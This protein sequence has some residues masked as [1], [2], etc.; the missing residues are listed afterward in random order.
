MLKK[1]QTWFPHT[2]VPRHVKKAAQKLQS[3]RCLNRPHWLTIDA[4]I[5]L[6]MVFYTCT[7]IFPDIRWSTSFFQQYMP[8]GVEITNLLLQG[9]V[10]RLVLLPIIASVDESGGTSL[11]RI[12]ALPGTRD[13]RQK[14]MNAAAQF[15]SALMHNKNAILMALVILTPMDWM[16]H[17]GAELEAC[18]TPNI[19]L[20]QLCF[21]VTKG[22]LVLDLI[23]GTAH[24]LAHKGPFKR[25]LWKYHMKHHTQPRN[26]SAVKYHGEALDLEV[27]LTQVCYA[28]LPRILGMDLFTGMVLVNW[29]SF[30]LLLEHTGFSCFYLSVH[31]EIHHRYA[32]VA[33]YHFPLWEMIF[34]R[35]PKPRQLTAVYVR[36][37][38]NTLGEKCKRSDQYTYPNKM[39]PYN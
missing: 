23:L 25:W 31:H 16:R 26:Y 18:P 37:N 34:G 17:S 38:T 13:K 7:N 24:M 19:S 8:V 21:S 11:I 29:F 32:S 39:T 28:F 33:F 6:A 27:L 30:Q 2:P 5:L 12:L 20:K 35:L 3:R 4:V 9:I 36:K 1:N 15:S 10:E 22:L 14:L